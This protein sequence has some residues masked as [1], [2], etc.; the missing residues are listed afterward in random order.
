V[1]QASWVRTLDT[2]IGFDA[3][4]PSVTKQVVEEEL[5]CLCWCGRE[6]IKVPREMVLKGRTGFCPCCA[7]LAGERS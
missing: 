6:I 1:N 2:G 3:K 7:K 4:I 5:N